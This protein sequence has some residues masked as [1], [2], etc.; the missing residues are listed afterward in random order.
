[1]TQD[2]KKVFIKNFGCQMNV[3]DSE[4]V[5]GLLTEKGYQLVDDAKEA[6]IVLF[7]TCSVREHAEHRVWSSVGLLSRKRHRPL[8]GI[9]GCMA[10]NYKNEV[11]K[12]APAVDLV[13][14]PSEIDNLALFLEE[15]L[16][17]QEKVIGVEHRNRKEVIYHTGFR[18]RKDHAYIVISEGCENFCSYCIVPFVR[19]PVRHR[20]IHEILKEITE[21]VDAGIENF[22]L[23]GQ[24]V[25]SYFSEG[26]GTKDDGRVDFVE[27]LEKAA[28][29]RGIKSLSFL[30][31]HP[32]DASQRLFEAMRDIPV[33]RKFLHMPAQS[34]SDRILKMMN[35]GYTAKKY[36]ELVDLYR[37]IVY[38]GEV[39][40]DFIVG[41]PT[42]SDEDFRQT[43]ELVK[44]VGF[45]SAFIFKYS[46]RT[47]TKA[48]ELADDV[49]RI[50]KEQ[51]HAELLELQKQIARTKR[52]EAK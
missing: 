29:I 18:D 35:R 37:S 40:S 51:R 16:K 12:K 1:M 8:I 17:K 11:F 31:S 39:S 48:A 44:E 22:T 14:G 19:G 28:G 30:T 45:D 7:N 25:N 26:R 50:V 6:D 24:N 21:A 9:M 23:L 49:P 36:L 52:H 27:L 20:F 4:V 10:Q 38:N 46:L 33:V 47:G 34:G 41:F 42:E 5:K 2:T 3:R 13:V 32:K 43:L 15:A